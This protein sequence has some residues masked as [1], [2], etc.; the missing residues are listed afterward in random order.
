[1]QFASRAAPMSAVAPGDGHRLAEGLEQIGGGGARG[2]GLGEDDERVDEQA[3]HG[4]GST[5][6]QTDQL[7]GDWI[8]FMFWRSGTPGWRPEAH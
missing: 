4:I 7:L 3:G 6:S 1:M 2:R 5:K 8:A